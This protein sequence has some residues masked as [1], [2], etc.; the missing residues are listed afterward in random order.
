MRTSQER[1]GRARRALR[2]VLLGL[3]LGSVATPAWAGPPAALD[4]GDRPTGVHRSFRKFADGWM[5][6]LADA[7]R[8]ERAGKGGAHRRY[9]S[10]YQLELRPTG[11]PRVPFVGILRYV[12]ER[13]NCPARSKKSCRMAKRTP[14]SEVFRFQ[15]GR[16]VY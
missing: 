2:P 13:W 12:E 4:P 3:A 5:Q 10:D 7:E 9:G 1:I 16:W 6:S 14:V 15:D 11:Q 8:S